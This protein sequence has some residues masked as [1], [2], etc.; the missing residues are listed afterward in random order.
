MDERVERD[1]I[2]LV[3]DVSGYTRYML[4]NRTAALHSQGIMTDLLEA[5]IRQVE[6]PLEVSKLEGDAVFMY[7][8]RREAADWE[9]IC[10]SLGSRLTVFVDAFDA[11][12]AELAATLVCP[13]AACRNLDKLRLKVVAH[14]GRA[15]RH[16]VGRFEELTGVDV[17][18]VHRL[19]KNRVQ[20]N[21]Y[22]LLTEPAFRRLQPPDSEGYAATVLEDKDLGA[23]PIRVRLLEAPHAPTPPAGRIAKAKTML[24]ELHWLWRAWHSPL[25]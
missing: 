25:N 3:A 5:V 19:L 9:T 11:K 23:V 20:G 14:A 12:L 22:L 7:A 1:M 6:I 17:I 13:C 2:L 15:V 10:R 21:S 8:E 24:L 18:L 4:E 16:N